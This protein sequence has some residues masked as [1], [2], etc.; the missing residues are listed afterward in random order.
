MVWRGIRANRHANLHHLNRGTLTGRDE[1][2]APYDRLDGPQRMLSW[3]TNTYNRR[4]FRLEWPAISP[5]LNPIEH[6]H[7]DSNRTKEVGQVELVLVKWAGGHWHVLSTPWWQSDWLL[8]HTA[9]RG[10][11]ITIRYTPLWFL[12]I[13]LDEEP[14]QLSSLGRPL[15]LR[16]ITEWLP[17][18]CMDEEQMNDKSREPHVGC[19]DLPL[20]KPSESVDSQ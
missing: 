2:L 4:I 9:R 8:V 14:A 15:F 17:C 18:L 6:L 7:F 1:I 12:G 20:R 11:S 13:V 3:W 10:R 5:D 19:L 16:G